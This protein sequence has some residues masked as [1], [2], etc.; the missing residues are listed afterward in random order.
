MLQ[1]TR[2]VMYENVPDILRSRK[3]FDIAIVGV[4]VL[5]ALASFGLGRLSVAVPA[6]GRAGVL[7]CKN[8][9]PLAVEAQTGQMA[10]VIGAVPDTEPTQSEGEYVASKNGSVYHLPWCS[11]AQR[12]AEENKV[13]FGSKAEAEAA[14]YRPAK[15]CKGI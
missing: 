7:V 12:I 3:A 8:G 5:V 9:L 10:G 6:E 14:G 2:S 4:L 11:G 15:N 1:I 13:Y